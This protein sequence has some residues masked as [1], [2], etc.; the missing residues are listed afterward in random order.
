MRTVTAIIMQIKNGYALVLDREGVFHKIEAGASFCVGQE[1]PL[2]TLAR[3]DKPRFRFP[4]K[5]IRIFAAAAMACA[6]AGMVMCLAILL[7]TPESPSIALQPPGSVITQNGETIIE[8]EPVPL[9]SP[10]ASGPGALIKAVLRGLIVCFVV[11]AVVFLLCFKEEKKREII[12][13]EE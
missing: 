2:P 5:R 1:I 9:A 4:L 13:S 3:S 7:N 8:D 6:F 11:L 12:R 10:E